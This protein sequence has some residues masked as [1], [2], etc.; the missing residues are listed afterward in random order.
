MTYAVYSLRKIGESS[1]VQIALGIAAANPGSAIIH[2]DGAELKVV[3]PARKDPASETL[4]ARKAEAGHVLLGILVA[5][6][7]A[8]AAIQIVLEN[9]PIKTGVFDFP[10][11]AK[12]AK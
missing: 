4:P 9:R 2:D 5:L 10:V 11:L 8:M 1:D 6:L 3:Y 12:E 7:L